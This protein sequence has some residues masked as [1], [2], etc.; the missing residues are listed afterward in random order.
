MSEALAVADLDYDLPA[1]LI[2]TEPARRRSDARLLLLDRGGVLRGHHVV[3]DLP[4]LLQPGDLLVV[5]ETA[6][7]P[8]RFIGRRADS[9]GRV[10]GLFL[11]QEASGGWVVL[12]QSNGR[13]RVGAVV[14]LGGVELRLDE[15]RQGSWVCTCSADAD[16]EVV[17]GEIGSTPLPPY[18]RRAREERVFDDGE[19]RRRYETVYADPLQR[20]SVAAPTAGLH[21]DQ[22]L[23][24]ALDDRGIARA[25]ITLHVGAGTFRPITADR[26]E[27]HRMHSEAWAVSQR[28]LDAIATAREEGRRV[29]AV[30]TTVVR[31]LESLPPLPSWPNSGGLCGVTE[32][33]IAPPW[34]FRLIDGLLTNFHLPRSTLLALVAAM[35]GI[36]PLRAAYAA[37]IAANYRFYSYGDAMLIA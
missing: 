9:G 17:L 5:N 27:D 30:G 25:A 7:L 15:K 11:S 36:Q 29:I 34:E 37:A 4:M 6:V 28:A 35:I 22:P 12:L 20:R 16:A 23:L 21:F 19:D 13:L 14:E 2:A 33:L 8:A 1:R 18:I 10:E 31:A 26:I 24:Q 32:L 3:R